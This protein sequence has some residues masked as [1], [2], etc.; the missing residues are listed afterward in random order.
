MTIA[1]DDWTYDDFDYS[2]PAFHE[3]AYP[4]KPLS[5]PSVVASPD[6]P[7]SVFSFLSERTQFQSMFPLRRFSQARCLFYQSLLKPLLHVI[8]TLVMLHIV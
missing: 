2:A 3:S 7:A 5:L 1:R 8:K 6:F 4:L